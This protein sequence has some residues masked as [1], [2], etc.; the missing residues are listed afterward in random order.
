MAIAP[1]RPDLQVHALLMATITGSIRDYFEPHFLCRD[2]LCVVLYAMLS[3]TVSSFVRLG[4][5]QVWRGD[6]RKYANTY[7]AGIC[8]LFMQQDAVNDETHEFV[9]INDMQPPST[10]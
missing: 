6:W 3:E 7:C 5:H 2:C 8:K 4:V 9:Y 10:K 1:S